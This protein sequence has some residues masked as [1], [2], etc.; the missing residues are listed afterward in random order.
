LSYRASANVELVLYLAHLFLPERS[1]NLNASQPGNALRG[2]LAGTTKSGVNVIGVQ[3][4]YRL[5]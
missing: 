5:N 3:L 4:N 1:V 2:N